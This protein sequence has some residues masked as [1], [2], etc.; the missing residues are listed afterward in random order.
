[1]DMI[2]YIDENGVWRVDNVPIC[3]TGIDYRLS[4]GH[5][6]FTQTELEDAVAAASGQD[7][8]IHPPRL[9]LGHASAANDLYLGG[10]EPAFGRVE[11][12]KLNDNHQTI[13]GDYVGTPEWLAK[14]LPV[15]YPSRSVDAALGVE[16]VTGKQYSMVITDVSLLGVRWPGCSV[17][18]DLP[19]WYGADVPDDAEVDVI[20]GINAE[21]GGGMK[22]GR[23]EKDL[24]A[25]VDVSLIRRAFYTK[26]PGMSE[27]NWWIRGE[28]FDSQEGYNLIVDMG[29]GELS[30]VPVNVTGSDP[31]FGDP[32]LVT[33]EYPDKAVAASAVLAG[34]RMADPAMIIHASRAETD[35][36]PVNT[37]QEGAAMDEDTRSKLAS[38]L[39]LPADATE[40]QI[41]STMAEQALADDAPGTPAADLPTGAN[42]GSPGIPP[43]QTAPETPATTPDVEASSEVVHLDRTKYEELKRGATL[44][45]SH[46]EER[47]NKRITDKLEAK[48]EDGTIP[49]ARRDHWKA[50]L[51]A[52]FEGAASVLDSLEPGMVPITQR[53]TAGADNEGIQASEAEGLPESWFPETKQIRNEAQQSRRVIHAKEG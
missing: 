34:M 22:L 52:D 6:T 7:I 12:L 2:P 27:P 43:E 19:I 46:E 14:V 50:R 17:I 30:R 45:A 35:D 40:A 25:A 15:A 32:V 42:D 48:I 5:H 24:A 23:K 20:A 51:E 29:D 53:G 10:D 3:S 39:G 11:N 49:P 18:E 47:V 9:K 28:R 44:A 41:N 4:T 33:E 37:T 16:T 1:M 36:R 38:K 31:E 8:A 21:D 26:G 13:Y